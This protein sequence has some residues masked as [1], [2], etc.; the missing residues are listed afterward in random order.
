MM[1]CCS[2]RSCYFR[3]TAAGGSH[4]A[5]IHVAIRKGR[6]RQHQGLKQKQAAARRGEGSL[7]PYD[8]VVRY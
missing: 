3:R 8:W 2:H 1:S 4:K 6:G 5:D 7:R